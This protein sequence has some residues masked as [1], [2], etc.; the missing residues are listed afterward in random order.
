VDRRIGAPLLIY[1][2]RYAPIVAASLKMH[3]RI[4]Q[5]KLVKTPVR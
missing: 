1:T 3:A 2:R 4:L 5:M